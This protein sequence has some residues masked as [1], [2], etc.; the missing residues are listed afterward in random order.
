[1][2]SRR[3]FISLSVAVV[4][5]GS[6]A[7]WAA[8]ELRSGK[9]DSP[10]TAVFLRGDATSDP[11][12]LLLRSVTIRRELALRQSQTASLEHLVGEVDEPL[13]RLRDAQ[14]VSD[15]SSKKAWELID[16]VERQVGTVLSREQQARLRQLMLQAR[17]LDALLHRDAME[18][19]K[20]SPDQ[21]RQIAETL[22]E[23]RRQARQLRAEMADKDKV[24]AGKQIEQF[25]AGQRK[26]VA[27]LLTDAQRRRWRRLIGRSFD[28]SHL[29]RRYVRR[30]RSA[31][32][33]HG[34]TPRR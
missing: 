21:T 15:G 5:L 11:L 10:S 3:Y 33:M 30:R 25:L 14:F 23:T 28:F 18:G 17:G 6:T 27:A 1:M 20:L 16:G 26:K 19:L 29:R 13:W 31:A 2:P 8:E 4:L 9:G 34:S 7:T 12:L 22:E 24:E 32:W